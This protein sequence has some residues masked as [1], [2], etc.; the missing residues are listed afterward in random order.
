[1]NRNNIKIRRLALLLAAIL[2][3]AAV[4]CGPQ[5]GTAQ[6][7]PGAV[8]EIAVVGIDPQRRADLPG[9]QAAVRQ[10]ISSWPGFVSWQSF[11]ASDDPNVVMDLLVWRSQA[12]AEAA[13]QLA[14]NSEVCKKYFAAIRSNL[15]FRHFRPLP[16]AEQRQ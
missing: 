8:M 14:Q 5:P 6:L 12:E 15:L 11:E 2:A 9:L 7:A 1:M 16:A 13:S 3:A 10:E 4:A